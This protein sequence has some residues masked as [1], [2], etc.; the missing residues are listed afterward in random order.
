VAK[1]PSV[2]ASSPRTGAELL[3]AIKSEI[4]APDCDT[5]AQCRSVGVGVRPCGGPEAFLIWSAKNGRPDRL[6]ALLAEHREARQAENARSGMMSDCRVMVDPGAV[7]RP[8]A[9]DG[10]RVC[11]PRQGGTA[12]VD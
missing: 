7:C 1:A 10:K 6:M 4:G 12:T 5:S 3:L 8:R 11:Q 2:A 9:P